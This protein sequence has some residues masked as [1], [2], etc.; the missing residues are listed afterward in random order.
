VWALLEDSIMRN[1]G[2]GGSQDMTS[3]EVSLDTRHSAG[4]HSEGMIDH[5]S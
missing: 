3:S 4:F 2:D 1:C 5:F